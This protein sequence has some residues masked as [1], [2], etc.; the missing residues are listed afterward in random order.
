MGGGEAE[1]F[2]VDGCGNGAGRL[3]V[4]AGGSIAAAGIAAESK[5]AGAR[6]KDECGDGGG[7]TNVVGSSDWDIVLVN[8]PI[9]TGNA[10]GGITSVSYESSSLSATPSPSPDEERR[11]T[12]VF[13]L[14]PA[15]PTTVGLT[16]DLRGDLRG[17]DFRKTDCWYSLKSRAAAAV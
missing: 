17:G 14:V 3:S 4:N 8:V 6:G 15:F 11:E 10:G 12:R 7:K 1:L 9:L 16:G 5:L 13:R 2:D